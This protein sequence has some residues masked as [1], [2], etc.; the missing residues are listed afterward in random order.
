MRCPL[1]ELLARAD[2]GEAVVYLL[3][4]LGRQCDGARRGR[5]LFGIETKGLGG[6]YATRGCMRLIEQAG[7]AQRSHN[8]ADS[9]SAHAVLVAELAGEHLRGH[10]FTCGDIVLDNGGQYQPLARA[11]SQIGSHGPRKPDFLEAEGISAEWVEYSFLIL[12]AAECWVNSLSDT[13]CVRSQS[14]AALQRDFISQAPQTLRAHRRRPAANRISLS[15]L[16]AG[17]QSAV[18]PGT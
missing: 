7:I 15:R 5:E 4:A 6:R 12:L 3:T 2:A 8:V 13:S 1:E 9:G 18:H 14:E 17:W 16:R 11:D 10:R